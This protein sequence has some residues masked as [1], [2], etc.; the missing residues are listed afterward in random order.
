MQISTGIKSRGSSPYNVRDLFRGGEAGVAASIAPEL[1][2]QDAAGTTPILA[3]GD[4][5]GLVLDTSQGVSARDSY[6]P[7]LSSQSSGTFS[8]NNT[9]SFSSTPT[10][11]T[12]YVLEYEITST[13]YTGDLY[14]EP[15]NSP[16]NYK[17][18]DKS[19]GKHTYYLRAGDTQTKI[20]TLGGA[21]SPTGSIT[22]SSISIREFTRTLSGLGDELVTNG[23]FEDGSTGW[24]LSGADINVGGGVLNV[25]SADGS[26]QYA[27]TSSQPL[28]VGKTYLLT[29]DLT[30]RSVGGVKFSSGTGS[31][32]GNFNTVG[33]KTLIFTAESTG[34]L[35]IERQSGVTDLDVDNVSVR[36]I[37]GNHAIQDIN[38]DYRPTLGRHPNSGLRN[39]LT[40]TEN[41][42]KWATSNG[43]VLVSQN[44]PT[45]RVSLDRVVSV[46]SFIRYISPDT[47]FTRTVSIDI[48]KV[49]GS[50]DV[51][52]IYTASNNADGNASLNLDTGAISGFGG[53]AIANESATLLPDGFW[54]VKFTSLTLPTGGSQIKLVNDLDSSTLTV[55]IRFPQLEEGSTATTYQKVT[56][57]Y[58]VTEAGKRDLWYLRPDG[59]DDYMYVPSLDMSA[60]DKVTVWAAVHKESD[61]ASATVCE[62]SSNLG[63][64]N[65]SFLV[66][67]PGNAGLDR[68]QWGSKG[69][70]QAVINAIGFVAPTTN[71]LTGVGDISG[72]EATLRVDGTQAATSSADQGTGNYG[73]YPLYIGARGGSN[74]FFDG[75]I[76][77]LVIRGGAST[78]VEIAKTERYMARLSGVVL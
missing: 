67:A 45:G 15:G 11:G 16:F 18:L 48:K 34:F 10:A 22:F 13:S 77:S 69:T 12:A 58:D 2:F 41:F 76:Y 28:T 78:D 37:P 35:Y 30:R 49:S 52:R 40:Y 60:S 73:T 51:V 39:L 42:G 38:D 5:V 71:V 25:K 74:R 3:A 61:A 62:L 57:Q 46:P 36:E 20:F 31:Y 63:I 56:S 75:R 44:G 33:P 4:P 64:N 17:V 26:Y 14:L 23:D 24:N 53:G 29:L 50:T 27:R 8:S 55:D 6:G 7:E 66:A 65:G 59:V 43:A 9:A 47:D 21:G 70:T 54:R 32:G 72:D 19:V 68:Y 1:C